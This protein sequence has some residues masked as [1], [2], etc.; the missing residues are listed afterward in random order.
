MSVVIGY[1]HLRL[2]KAVQE[3]LATASTGSSA[4]PASADSSAV[5]SVVVMPDRAGRAHHCLAILIEAPVDVVRQDPSSKQRALFRR[6]SKEIATTLGK[7]I[8]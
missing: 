5:G 2:G 4:G 3:D 1:R 6:G 8:G 7:V